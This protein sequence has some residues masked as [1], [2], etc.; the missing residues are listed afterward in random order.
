MQVP[1]PERAAIIPAQGLGFQGLR[2][3][4]VNI[5]ILNVREGPGL[6]SRIVGTLKRNEIV[7]IQREMSGWGEVGFNRWVMLSYTLPAG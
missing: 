6:S 1:H 4:K 7:E 2:R 3:V 5:G